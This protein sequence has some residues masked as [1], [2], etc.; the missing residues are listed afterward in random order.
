MW[1]K[2]KFTDEVLKGYHV[3]LQHQLGSKIPNGILNFFFKYAYGRKGAKKVKAQGMGVHKPEEISEFGRRD[4]KVLSEQLGD[5]PFF[6]GDE[7]TSVSTTT[8]VCRH[9]LISFSRMFADVI[10]F[11]L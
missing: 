5:K 3:S 4:L 11:L 1:W 2:T 10:A 6:F 9:G 7:P 8:I